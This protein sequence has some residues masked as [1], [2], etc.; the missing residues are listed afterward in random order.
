MAK[1]IKESSTIPEQLQKLISRGL[2][3][4]DIFYANERLSSIGY[5]N[6]INA[7]KAPFLRTTG[8]EKFIPGITFEDI[9][10]IYRFDKRQRRILQ[11]TLEDIEQQLRQITTRKFI[12]VHGDD[13]EK[14]YDMKAFRA[15]KNSDAYRR[16]SNKIT[17]PA[18]ENQFQPFKH[19]REKYKGVPLWVA[20]SDWDFG[21]LETF[22]RQLKP[23]VKEKIIDEFFS[24]DFKN[25]MHNEKFGL[26]GFFV[27]F[28]ILLRMFRNRV[29]HGY[30]VYNYR[31]V[32]VSKEGVTRPVLK[33]YRGFQG[34]EGI[35]KSAYNK[36]AGNGDIHLLLVGLGKLRYRSPFIQL[37]NETLDNLMQS[38]HDHQSVDYHLMSS[39][40]YPVTAIAAFVR[41]SI[42]RNKI[43]QV[44]N[45]KL[46]NIFN[47]YSVESSADL[48]VV[49]P[50]DLPSHLI[51]NHAY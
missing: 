30:R 4:N 29:S 24:D 2:I 9:D 42:E 28:L 47:Y 17:Y 50:E 22:I 36:G 12:E 27:E 41:N 7:Y 19:Y 10:N 32:A 15:F 33:Y 51:N 26:E 40:G 16:F 20:M 34:L 44:Q 13:P 49:K 5:Y 21:T 23:N 48:I 43:L 38:L 39:M 1:P 14:Y 25:D 8:A 3:I 37:K 45:P 11:N 46:S 6:I 18:L 31:P 35:T